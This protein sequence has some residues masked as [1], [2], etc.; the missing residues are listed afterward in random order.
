[1]KT[2]FDTATRSGLIGRIYLLNDKSTAQWGKMN[3]YEMLSHCILF[4][5]MIQGKTKYKRAFLGR[6]FG[7]MALKDFIG[8]ERPVKR[9]LPTIPGLV[10]KQNDGEIETQK[11]QWVTL[12]EGYANYPDIDF[13]HS[14]FGKLTREQSG[15]LVYK[16]IDHHLRQFNN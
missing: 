7:K 11:K 9:N 8:D 4:D 2:I 6:L 1:M 15:Y 5:E 14:F 13:V 16:H 12:I 3:I 10:V